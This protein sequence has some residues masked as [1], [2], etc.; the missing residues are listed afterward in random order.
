[1]GMAR[2][3]TSYYAFSRLAT[4]IWLVLVRRE[5]DM[6][7]DDRNETVTAEA[8]PRRQSHMKIGRSCVCPTCGAGSRRLGR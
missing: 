5:S 8:A 6:V 2:S 3:N 7:G 1:M 4:Q